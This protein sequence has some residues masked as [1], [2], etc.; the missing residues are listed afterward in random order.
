MGVVDSQQYSE[1]QNA[2]TSKFLAE[3]NYQKAN[4]EREPTERILVE[5]SPEVE[6]QLEN[7]SQAQQSSL[8]RW[9]S[10]LKAIAELPRAT[11]VQQLLHTIR[12]L[13]VML[14]LWVPMLA[15]QTV[16]KNMAV[17]HIRAPRSDLAE[18]NRTLP[19]VLLDHWP[20]HQFS[21]INYFTTAQIVCIF[22]L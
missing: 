21:I 6:S 18:L 20:H 3:Q 16:L 5:H 9:A 15:V 17:A 7:G 12:V 11:W 2:S 10:A 22:Y 14:A 13:L 8:L 4:N 19:D 1:N